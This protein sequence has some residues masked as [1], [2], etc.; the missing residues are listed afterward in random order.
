M[1][2]SNPFVNRVE[3]LY[4][5]ALMIAF[6]VTYFFLFSSTA[7]FFPYF[8]L[9]LKARGFSPSQVG[10]LL[11]CAQIA[12]IVGPLLVGRFADRSG[13][14]RLLLFLALLGSAR[15]TRL[16]KSPS[17]QLRH[18]Y[19]PVCVRAKCPPRSRQRL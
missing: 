15:R 5:S 6:A 16:E 3:S 7:V 4:T 19:A 10:V 9:F 2:D 11:A 17:G 13:R 8:Q 14:Y 18:G 12:G 1:L